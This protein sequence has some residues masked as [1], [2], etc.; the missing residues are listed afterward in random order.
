[1]NTDEMLKNL[2]ILYAED[3][4]EAREELTDV[5]KRRVGRVYVCE[6]GARGLEL[7]NDC[8]PDII[9][10]DYYMPEMDG[11][12]MIKRIH[13]QGDNIAAVIISAVDEV[14]T[15]LRAIDAGICKYI[16]KPVNVQDLLG[17]LEELAEELYGS[18]KHKSAAL[19][20]NRKKVED[21]IKREF[22]A[23]LKS[24]TGKGPRN[25][26]V[27]MNGDGIEVMASDVL[28]V[29]EKNILDSNRNVG[30]IKHI[31][32]LFFSVK[33]KE[34]CDMIQRISGCKVTLSDV[35]ISPEKDKNRL[36]F[37]VSRGR[38]C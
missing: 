28:T 25:V 31:R 21:E 20:E 4:E 34:L 18:R 3:D 24:S 15:I 12:E 9:I 2:K 30:I 5:L 16:L 13:K 14:N 10:A 1:M 29:F 11:I 23:M 36:I 38:D 6:N 33:E 27:F 26:S 17:V 35:I 32:E 37:T 8:K 22:S 7:Y 19:P